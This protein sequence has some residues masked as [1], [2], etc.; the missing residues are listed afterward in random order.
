MLTK[1]QSF[2]KVILHPGIGALLL[3][4][5]VKRPQG[6]QGFL[7]LDFFAVR[8][9]ICKHVGAKNKENCSPVLRKPSRQPF[10]FRH[11]VVYIVTPV[12]GEDDSGVQQNGQRDFRIELRCYLAV[13]VYLEARIEVEILGAR[14]QKRLQTSYLLLEFGYRLL[15]VFIGFM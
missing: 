12:A 2:V 14:R 13:F 1:S 6:L 11:V 9:G 8:S 7:T 3:I 10:V 4:P 15:L 5:A